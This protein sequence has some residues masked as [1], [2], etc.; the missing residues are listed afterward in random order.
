MS[1][2]LVTHYLETTTLS[3]HLVLHQFITVLTVLSSATVTPTL[4]ERLYSNY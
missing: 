1:E 3:N 4:P 2:T